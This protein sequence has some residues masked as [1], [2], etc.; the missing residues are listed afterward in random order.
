MGKRLEQVT[1]EFNGVRKQLE[2]MKQEKADKT[3]KVTIRKAVDSLE[4]QCQKMKERLFEI[5]KEVTY[6]RV[7]WK[8]I[9]KNKN[10]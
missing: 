6:L 4:Q 9:V 2:K 3:L 10:S 1:E 7:G 5:K 8:L